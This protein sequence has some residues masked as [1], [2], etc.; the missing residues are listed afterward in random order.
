MH[1][2]R[3]GHDSTHENEVNTNSECPRGQ[4]IQGKPFL[5]IVTNEVF[6][7]T[8][9]LGKTPVRYLSRTPVPFVTCF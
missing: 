7:H 8:F 1:V 3:N 6:E 9:N 5:K 2:R 4:G